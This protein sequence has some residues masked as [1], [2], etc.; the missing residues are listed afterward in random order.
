MMPS[1]ILK[2]DDAHPS[3]DLERARRLSGNLL[4]GTGRP[5]YDK[6]GNPHRS[7][8]LRAPLGNLR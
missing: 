7:I 4:Y 6:L 8:Q 2:S 3:V 5:G 1:I